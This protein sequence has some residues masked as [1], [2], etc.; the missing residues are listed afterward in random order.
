MPRNF[1]ILGSVT[2]QLNIPELLAEIELRRTWFASV[3]TR[4]RERLRVVP[5]DSRERPSL[6][7]EISTACAVVDELESLAELITGKEQAP[8]TA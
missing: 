4:R 2:P 1:E 7:Q 6:I 8:R 5:E 3:A